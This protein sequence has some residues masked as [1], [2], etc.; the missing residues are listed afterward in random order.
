MAEYIPSPAQWVR[1]Q[2]ELYESRGGA[3]GT[4]LRETGLPVTPR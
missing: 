2:V 1:G 3:E 4:T